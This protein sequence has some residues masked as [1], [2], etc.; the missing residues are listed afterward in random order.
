M[1]KINIYKEIIKQVDEK[2]SKSRVRNPE[3]RECLAENL[4]YDL[5]KKYIQKNKLDLDI[6]KTSGEVLDKY[7]NLERNN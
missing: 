1:T 3:A 6:I 4:C 7:Y 5:T 2:L